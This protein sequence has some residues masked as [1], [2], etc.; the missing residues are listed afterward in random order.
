MKLIILAPKVVQ[1]YI[2]K[3]P[4]TGNN[5]Y[6]YFN[7]DR[8]V[9]EER[10]P[11][12]DVVSQYKGPDDF[13][14]IDYDGLVKYAQTILNPIL[15]KYSQKVACEDALHQAIRSYNNGM[16]DNKVNAGR[17]NVLLQAMLNP[18]PVAPICQCQTEC[19]MSSKKKTE[20]PKSKVLSPATVKTLGLKTEDIPLKGQEKFKGP[21]IYRHRGRIHVKAS[22]GTP[23]EYLTDFLNMINEL[24][25]KDMDLVRK[26]VGRW[27]LSKPLIKDFL[28]GCIDDCGMEKEYV[29]KVSEDVKEAVNLLNKLEGLYKTVKDF[30][31]EEIKTKM[32]PL[33]DLI[34]K[35]ETKDQAPSEET[36]TEVVPETTVEKMAVHIPSEKE[37]VMLKN[38]Q[39]YTER[40]DK[41]ADEIQSICP[42][43]A[44]QLD[45]ISD[46]IEGKRDASS[47]KFDA[48]EAR[49]MQ[50]RFNSNPQKRDADEPYMD[51]FKKSNFEQVK[52]IRE[53]PE[54]IKT[55]ESLPY[56]KVEEKVEG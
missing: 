45:I 42:E 34:S 38:A 30:D 44:L 9:Y 39:E 21:R 22:D 48:D 40:L 13:S 27:E 51:D 4:E 8:R 12:G 14:D 24:P 16:F 23:N 55:S 50:D 49:Y 26:I 10:V 32:E 1:G 52:R 46:V 36:P 41:I 28:S 6:K 53:T 20:E 15:K 31:M 37:K 3:F 54:P 56:R 47:L 19:R 7:Y 2:N 35:V 5:A 43:A 33:L 17:Y 29:E 11:R 25:T 18:A